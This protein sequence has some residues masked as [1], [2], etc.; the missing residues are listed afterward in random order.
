MIIWYYIGMNKKAFTPLEIRYN[1][2]NKKLSKGKLSPTGFT[3]I[4]LLVTIV[5]IGLL[6]GLLVPALGRAR[7]SGRRS[8]C[9]N[10]L[11]QIGMAWHMYIDDSGRFPYPVDTTAPFE[12]TW[13][14]VL[15]AKYID[16]VSVFRCLSHPKW[17]S[18]QLAHA[19]YQFDYVMKRKWLGQTA[20]DL[21]TEDDIVAGK[22]ESAA[23]SLDYYYF[24]W[25]DLSRHH[26][27]GV[28]ILYWDGHVKW[29]RPPP[30]DDPPYTG[31]GYGIS[32]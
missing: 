4:E 1:T 14:G 27:G 26:S 30:P 29:H 8:Q 15:A 6:A 28:N 12:T 17:D 3:L 32:L 9:M 10:N 5:I 25:E 13:Y 2:F 18:S 19:G 22:K 11:R 20:R 16:D 31:Y 7:E 24:N 21:R 23:P